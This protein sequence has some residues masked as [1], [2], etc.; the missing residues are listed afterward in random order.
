M[1]CGPP[2]PA[3]THCWLLLQEPLLGPFPFRSGKTQGASPSPSPPMCLAHM[4][5]LRVTE[6]LAHWP[7]AAQRQRQWVR[8]RRHRRR[9]AAAISADHNLC[10]TSVLLSL[11]AVP[12][13]LVG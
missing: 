7:E 2:R 6:E 11:L 1:H 8:R 4:F 3:R 12:A 10:S 5:A 13:V 9:A